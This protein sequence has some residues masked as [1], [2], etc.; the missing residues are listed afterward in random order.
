[1]ILVPPIAIAFGD[2]LLLPSDDL[3]F[4]PSDPSRAELYGLGKSAFR[5]KL[6]NLSAP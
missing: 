4:Q 3:T 1:M 5:N 2:A 6:L